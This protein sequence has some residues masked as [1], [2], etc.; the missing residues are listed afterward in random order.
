MIKPKYFEMVN[1]DGSSGGNAD[2]PDEFY[3]AEDLKLYELKTL[4]FSFELDNN[5]FEDFVMNNLCLPLMSYNLKS[6]FDSYINKAPIFK[7]LPANVISK[8]NNCIEYFL[9][10]FAEKPDVLDFTK[11]RMIDDDYIYGFFSYEKIKE[12]SLFPQPRNFDGSLVISE[13]IKNQIV[14]NNIKGVSF[15]EADIIF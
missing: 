8:N 10:L 2:A 4:P 7:W 14:K 5:I 13:E 1:N 15:S 3:Y 9:M 6:I 11:T 12:F